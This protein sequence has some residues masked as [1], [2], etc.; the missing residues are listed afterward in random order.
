[1]CSEW[2]LAA[3]RVDP[4]RRKDRNEEVDVVDTMLLVTAAPAFALHTKN[5]INQSSSQVNQNSTQTLTAN[6]TA[7]A[8]GNV[9]QSNTQ[10]S[11]QYGVR[12]FIR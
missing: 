1:M 2:F 9:Q 6:Q 11:K 8:S 4:K 5:S 12:A 10:S 3:G 7:T